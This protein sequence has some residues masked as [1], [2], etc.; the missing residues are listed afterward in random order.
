MISMMSSSSDLYHYSDTAERLHSVRGKGLGGESLAARS[1]WRRTLASFRRHGHEGEDVLS[2]T[3]TQFS[4]SL[5]QP[6]CT[7]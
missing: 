6:L 1:L 4:L 2:N 5:F 7:V 3:V